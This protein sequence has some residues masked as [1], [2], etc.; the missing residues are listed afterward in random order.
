MKVGVLSGIYVVNFWVYI[1]LTFFI[2]HK[3]EKWKYDV[4]IEDVKFLVF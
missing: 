2:D 3:N 1:L 4:A